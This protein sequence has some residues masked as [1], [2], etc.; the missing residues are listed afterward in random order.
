MLEGA[1]S[2]IWS[3]REVIDCAIR[4]LDERAEEGKGKEV[5]GR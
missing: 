1:R 5:E 3:C 4:E 2:A